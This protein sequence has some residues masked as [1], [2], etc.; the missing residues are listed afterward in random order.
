MK[1]RRVSQPSRL[2]QSSTCRAPSSCVRRAAAADQHAAFLDD[3]EIAA[4]ERAGRHHVVD[5]NA[6]PLIGADGGVVL[7]APP[8]VGHRG[9]D[10]PIGRHDAGI[11]GIDLHRQFRLRARANEW[12][13]RNADRRRR[14]SLCCAWASWML[15]GASRKCLRDSELVA[16]CL[17]W[18]GEPEQHVGQ[19]HRFRCESPSR[20]SGAVPPRGSRRRSAKGSEAIRS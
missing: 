1:A 18:S 19:R 5:R 14:R 16:R 11:A 3:V 8:P 15:Q 6:E 20:V 2:N 13:R 7:A 12:R 9:D 17:R 4:L 10:R